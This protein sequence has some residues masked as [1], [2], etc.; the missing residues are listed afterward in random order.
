MYRIGLFSQITK[1]T[2]KALRYYDEV[3]LLVP[4]HVDQEN[5]YR[6]YTTGQLVE[7]HKI[8]SLRQMG[9]SI[10]EVLAIIASRNVEEIVAQRKAEIV[11]QIKESAD[12]LSRINHYILEQK[13]GHT[14]NYQAVIKQIPECIVY[15]KRMIA[16]DYNAYFQIIPAIG[17]EVKQANPKLKCAVPEYCFIIYHDGEYKEK[18]IDI[19]YCEAVTEAGI[20]TGGITFKTMPGITAVS[21]MHKGPYQNLSQAYAY[22]FKWVEDNGYS[23]AGNPRESYIDGIWNKENEEEWLTELQV[24]VFKK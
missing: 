16:P 22:T 6:Y 8:I 23:I 15:S 14:M 20:E 17:E 2:I 24:P 1:T 7:L 11:G 4:A 13:E 21:V 19:E 10:D 3:G 9:F 18:D 5:G 12:Q